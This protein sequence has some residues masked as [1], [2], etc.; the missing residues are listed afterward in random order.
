MGDLDN[1]KG[2]LNISKSWNKDSPNFYELESEFREQQHA[3]RNIPSHY[4]T[5][6]LSRKVPFT[7]N[8]INKLPKNFKDYILKKLSNFLLEGYLYI[9]HIV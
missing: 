8:M 1:P 4:I 3:M 2:S 5:T 6:K 9:Y 7:Y